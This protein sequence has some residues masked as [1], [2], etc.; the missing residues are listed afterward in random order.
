MHNC[1]SNEQDQTAAQM[2]VEEEPD[3]T[4]QQLTA[5]NDKELVG[6]A[7]ESSSA[8]ASAPKSD[9]HFSPS[10]LSLGPSQPPSLLAR[11]APSIPLLS[12]LQQENPSSDGPSDRQ[13][14][15]AAAPK[16]SASTGSIPATAETPDDPSFAQLRNQRRSVDRDGKRISFSSLYSLSSSLCSGAVDKFP[17]TAASSVAGSVKNGMEEPSRTSA[18]TQG[19]NTGNNPSVSSSPAPGLAGTSSSSRDFFLGSVECLPF[20]NHRSWVCCHKPTE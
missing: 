7:K 19:A 16:A 5:G 18:L 1:P 11:R 4:P 3:T 14:E 15:P 13:Q 8:S 20:V 6:A 9:G 12:A 2:P 17:S 10:P